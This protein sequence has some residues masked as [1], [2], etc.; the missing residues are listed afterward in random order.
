M[1]AYLNISVSEVSELASVAGNHT[2]WVWDT[3]K[4]SHCDCQGKKKHPNTTQA[5]FS[6]YDYDEDRES[7]KKNHFKI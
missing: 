4:H 5:N 3:S 6:P 7:G 2:T 1:E